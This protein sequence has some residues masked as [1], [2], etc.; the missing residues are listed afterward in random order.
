MAEAEVPLELGP[1]KRG[2][3]GTT[4]FEN[5]D[6]AFCGIHAINMLFQERKVVWFPGCPQYIR[7]DRLDS[8]DVVYDAWTQA[9]DIE[10]RDFSHY[11]EANIETVKPIK[12]AN[13][14]EKKLLDD[15]F[16][17]AKAADKGFET[18]MKKIAK[19]ENAAKTAA[20]AYGATPENIAAWLTLDSAYM[21]EHTA[22][23]QAA[24]LAAAA[25]LK[26]SPAAPPN[27]AA[28]VTATTSTAAAAA[29]SGAAA[30]SSGAAAAS[31][32]AA[33]ATANAAATAKSKAIAAYEVSVTQRNVWWLRFLLSKRRTERARFEMIKVGRSAEAMPA[34]GMPKMDA[35]NSGVLFNIAAYCS[36]SWSKDQKII[37][38]R[39]SVKDEA[40]RVVRFHTRPPPDEADES[41]DG[42][43]RDVV[44]YGAAGV[45]ITDL[46]A[47]TQYM[48]DE[49]MA[50]PDHA[51]QEYMCKVEERGNDGDIPALLIEYIMWTQFNYQSVP[52]PCA[53]LP[54]VE[55]SATVR[56]YI[57]VGGALGLIVNYIH[58][59]VANHYCAV[60]KF[61]NPP[62]PAT[63]YAIGDSIFVLSPPQN[64]ITYYTLDGL[65]DRLLGMNV[66]HITCVFAQVPSRALTVAVSRMIAADAD[67][68]PE[69]A[70]HEEENAGYEEE[71]A[72]YEEEAAQN[73]N[74][75]NANLKEALA[76]SLG[77]LPAG[78]KGGSRKTRRAS[79]P[80]RN[81]SNRRI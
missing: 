29:S 42:F 57:K 61:P 75:E 50:E 4:Y 18:L 71:N 68:K 43:M 54:P 34:E 27:A 30:A 16:K 48:T 17:Q 78:S 2:H 7:K 47:V 38:I 26:A 8:V 14:A 22:H 79:K 28:A 49:A 20:F 51:L 65:I 44:K 32:G 19:D 56:N 3:V 45:N 60:I 58:P 6:E 63:P 69:A 15:A 21:A 64:V 53:D 13:R 40:E 35:T 73:N 62:D 66:R 52:I 59:H 1:V 37:Q 80:R 25:A 77:Q 36:D 23:L 10:N 67:I 72:G 11:I 5:Q 33:A 76:L 12:S 24:E 46:E 74:D 55:W 9:R 41:Y 81:K 39:M 70:G 31:S